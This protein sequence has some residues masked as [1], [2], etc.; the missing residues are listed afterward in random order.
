[1]SGVCTGTFLLHDRED[2]FNFCAIKFRKCAQEQFKKGETKKELSL[3][4]KL[5][6]KEN[7]FEL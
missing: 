5:C 6:R 1:M 7:Y 4:F 2:V 3:I